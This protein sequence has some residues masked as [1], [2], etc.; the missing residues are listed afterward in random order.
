MV[1]SSPVITSGRRALSENIAAIQVENLDLVP[2]F[3]VTVNV[4]IKQAF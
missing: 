1:D 3:L 4:I 2:K